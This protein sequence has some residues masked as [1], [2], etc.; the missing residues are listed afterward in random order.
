MKP[1]LLAGASGLAAI[2][3]LA[4][5][6]AAAQPSYQP[7]LQD[8][9]AY[10]AEHPTKTGDFQLIPLRPLQEVHGQEG[11]VTIQNGVYVLQGP[12]GNVTVQIGPEG[13]VVVDSARKEHGAEL[14]AELKKLTGPHTMRFFFETNGDPER[15]EAGQ[16]VRNAGNAIFGGNMAGQAGDLAHESVHM[17]HENV[18]N[19]LSGIGKD[20][21]VDDG[22][23]PKE[24]YAE[25]TYDFHL[26]GEGIQFFHEPA[27]HTDGDSIVF[28]RRSDVVVAGD[29]WDSN[30]Y[31]RIDVAHGGSIQGELDALNHIIAITIPGN[32]QEGGTLVVPGRG[33][34]GDEAELVEYRD[35]IT[36]IRDRVRDMAKKGMTLEQIKAAKPS[37]D[38][39]GRWGSTSGPWTTDMFISAVYDGVKPQGPQKKGAAK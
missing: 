17:S 10:A 31:P 25:A 23:W 34:P 19:R 14:V 29:V 6:P 18:L 9:L 37:F 21:A 28:F 32:K 26:N 13:S 15:T 7:A 4:A 8:Q 5:Q 22:L 38:Y 35:M 12:D 27:A 36:I 33:R 20:K 3:M 2:A 1:T 16:M 11:V 30:T 39:D 24:T